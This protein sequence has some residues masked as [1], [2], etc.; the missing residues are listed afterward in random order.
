M[1]PPSAADLAALAAR[2][3][4][5]HDLEGPE[6]LAILELPGMRGCMA[7]ALERMREAY[8]GSK[9]I[10][11]RPT[12]GDGR[13]IRPTVLKVYPNEEAMCQEERESLTGREIF[14]D[15]APTIEGS[16]VHAPSGNAVL[17]LEVTGSKICLPDFAD[18]LKAV[19]SFGKLF[20]EATAT[21]A[22]STAGITGVEEHLVKFLSPEK[23]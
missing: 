18:A 4:G 11:A 16:A 10:F 14:A 19:R 23:S 20:E 5:E 1:P 15:F 12:G 22:V 13:K 9:V 7:V 3:S 2:F 8:G 17:Q 21:A 6:L